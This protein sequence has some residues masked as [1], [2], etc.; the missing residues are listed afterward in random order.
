MYCTN[1]RSSTATTT[2][3]PYKYLTEAPVHGQKMSWDSNC[4]IRM[5]TIWR[6]RLIE[7]AAGYRPA[8]NTFW[9]VHNSSQ[10]QPNRLMLLWISLAGETLLNWLLCS[11]DISETLNQSEV[12]FHKLKKLSTKIYF[13]W[14]VEPQ[15]WAKISPAH[16]TLPDGENKFSNEVRPS[17]E[18]KLS[19]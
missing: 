13:K 11:A 17:P 2:D 8:H 5:R 14:M 19:P 15:Q 12:R 1:T 16:S 3:S 9:D 6:I 4:W 10:Y 18:V 7:D